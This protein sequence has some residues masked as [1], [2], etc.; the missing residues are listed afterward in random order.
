MDVSAAWAVGVT[1][2]I[3]GV[4][5][6]VVAAVVV[7]GIDG[8]CNARSGGVDAIVGSV[9]KEEGLAVPF[10]REEDASTASREDP[11]RFLEAYFRINCLAF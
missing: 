7:G 11:S 3:A 9:R 4:L 2:F 5:L 6:V 8:V 1:A 10:P